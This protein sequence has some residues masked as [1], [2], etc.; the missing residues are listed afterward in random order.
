[1]IA[2]PPHPT[3]NPTMTFIKSLVH[4][5]NVI[6]DLMH[7]MN[8]DSNQRKMEATTV[9]VERRRKKRII[10]PITTKTNNSHPH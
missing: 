7:R 6:Y 4:A 3:S 1:M 8:L 2:S 9:V 10:I 5:L